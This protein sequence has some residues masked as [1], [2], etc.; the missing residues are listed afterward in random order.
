[1]SK[2]ISIASCKGGIGKSV[3]TVNIGTSLAMQGHKVLVADID[4]QHNLSTYLNVRSIAE[5]SLPALMKMVME[6]TADD[7]LDA[8]LTEAVH[9]CIVKT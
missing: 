8:K 3:G 1:M 2:I 9:R 7:E 4:S 5:S 6:N